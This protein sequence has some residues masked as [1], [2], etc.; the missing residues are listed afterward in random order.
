VNGVALDDTDKEVLTAP[1]D[2]G[3]SVPVLLT[4]TTPASIL[5]GEDSAAIVGTV[6]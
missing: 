5:S 2:V 1:L 6:A 3:A 4:W